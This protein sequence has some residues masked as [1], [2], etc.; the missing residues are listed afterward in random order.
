MKPHALLQGALLYVTVHIHMD[1][2]RGDGYPI[3]SSHPPFFLFF[4]GTL[5]CL[6]LPVF[7]LSALITYLLT[8][9]P[10]GGERRRRRV[11]A[12]RAKIS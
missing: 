10:G 6:T 5:P 2:R 7:F 12:L 11:A 8:N 9:T 4:G 3:T 1:A